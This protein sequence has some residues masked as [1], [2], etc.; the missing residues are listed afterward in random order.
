MILLIQTLNYHQSYYICPIFSQYPLL[1]RAVLVDEQFILGQWQP[2]NSHSSQIDSPDGCVTGW[3]GCLLPRQNNQRKVV[4]GKSGTYPSRQSTGSERSISCSA[5]LSQGLV[6]QGCI[7]CGTFP[8][9]PSDVSNSRD[10]DKIKWYS[11]QSLVSFLTPATG[12][13]T[14]KFWQTFFVQSATLT[15][16]PE[17]SLFRFPCT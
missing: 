14:Q 7:T 2:H 6:S 9:S 17:A 4:T 12:I 5:I 16:L 11:Q 1:G 13:L 10:L 3:V 8:L 15:S